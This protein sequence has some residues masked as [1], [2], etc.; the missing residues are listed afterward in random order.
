M[1]DDHI[2]NVGS[3]QTEFF[4][5]IDHQLFHIPI[6][7]RIHQD[8][9]GGCVDGPDVVNIRTQIVEVIEH[10][11]RLDIPLVVRPRNRL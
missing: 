7:I 5:P 3:V 8:D 1:R 11:R 10:P 9:S 2:F 6:E 4:Q